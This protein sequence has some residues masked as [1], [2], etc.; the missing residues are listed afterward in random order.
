MCYHQDIHLKGVLGET[1]FENLHKDVRLLFET[2][3]ELKLTFAALQ[4]TTQTCPVFYPQSRG[5]H[6]QP[7]TRPIDAARD[8]LLGQLH[9]AP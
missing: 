7:D 6:R 2:L 8:S 4:S 5:D 1:K 3:D 9:S